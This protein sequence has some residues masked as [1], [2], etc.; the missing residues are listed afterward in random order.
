MFHL[1]WSIIGT[2]ENLI[3]IPLLAFSIIFSLRHAPKKKFVWKRIADEKQWIRFKELKNSTCQVSLTKP[4]QQQQQQQITQKFIKI[5]IEMALRTESSFSRVYF[6]LKFNFGNF[7]L[8]ALPWPKIHFEERTRYNKYYMENVA[9]FSCH[10]ST[11]M[12]WE[13]TLDWGGMTLV[14]WG[15]LLGQLPVGRF[16]SSVSVLELKPIF[17]EASHRDL[18]NRN[19]GIISISH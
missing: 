2:T 4:K 6:S 12:E 5:I 9:T 14:P 18:P 13:C 8:D 1:V 10:G 11:K 3:K 16:R 19:T 17:P 15:I 7:S